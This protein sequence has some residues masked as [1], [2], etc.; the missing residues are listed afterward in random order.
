[1]TGFM[2]QGHIYMHIWEKKNLLTTNFWKFGEKKK[3]T[4]DIWKWWSLT[5]YFVEYQ[6][7]CVLFVNEEFVDTSVFLD[8]WSNLIYNNIFNYKIHPLG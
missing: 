6:G 3:E 8:L 4:F 7:F 2:V 1:M 5:L